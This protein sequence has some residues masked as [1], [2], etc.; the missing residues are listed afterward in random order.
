MKKEKNVLLLL[1]MIYS[2]LLPAFILNCEGVVIM[3][4]IKQQYATMSAASWLQGCKDITI[5]VSSFA[6][7]S[8]I[9]KIGYKKA[10][11]AATFIQMIICVLMASFVTLNTSRI[12]FILAG[13]SFAIVKIT[14]YSSVGTFTKNQSQHAGFLS[15]LEGVYMLGIL[16][17]FWIFSFFM[18]FTGSWNNTFWFLAVLCLIGLILIIVTPFKNEASKDEIVESDGVKKGLRGYIDLIVKPV[19]FLFIIL[20]V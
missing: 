4:L 7:I 8:I 10:L 9:S 11:F 14:I 18:S 15:A 1:V 13:L 16:S 6:L 3:N 5:M 12:Y 2:F 17:G 20:I 19:F